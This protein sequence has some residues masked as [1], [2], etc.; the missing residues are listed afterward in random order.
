MQSK[1]FKSEE[2]STR[3]KRNETKCSPL[4]M[5]LSLGI[6]TRS[7]AHEFNDFKQFYDVKK[8][9]GTKTGFLLGSGRNS[10]TLCTTWYKTEKI[11][12][13]HIQVR[14]LMKL[15]PMPG[16]RIENEHR[17]QLTIGD[18][19]FYDYFIGL[20]LNELVGRT[21]PHLIRTLNLLRVLRAPPPEQPTFYQTLKEHEGKVYD[22][23]VITKELSV[24]ESSEVFE[25]DINVKNKK[26]PNHNLV[27]EACRYPYR[28]GVSYFFMADGL[29]LGNFWRSYMEMKFSEPDYNAKVDALQYSTLCVLLQVYAF[30]HLHKKVF[31]HNDL[32]SNNIFLVKAPKQQV[33]VF[34]YYEMIYDE[35]TKRNEKVLVLTFRSRYLVKIIDYGRCYVKG[36]TESFRTVVQQ[37]DL[38]DS[39]K[40]RGCFT[41]AYTKNVI[42][43]IDQEMKLLQEEALKLTFN[44][45]TY[46]TQPSHLKT[47]T[48]LPLKIATYVQKEIDSEFTVSTAYR[49][50]FNCFSTDT[51][52]KNK[53]DMFKNFKVCGEFSILMGVP[54]ENTASNEDVTAAAVSVKRHTRYTY[55]HGQQ[56]A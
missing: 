5:C 2:T 19:I 48:P 56:T 44:L 12:G 22:G 16:H 53:K 31:R 41:N 10:I 38:Y 13:K 24:I 47:P 6:Y 45:K 7:I 26:Q 18:N 30:L 50:L 25:S 15:T 29:T 33:F 8:N 52:K 43:N 17:E 42:D 9:I 34:N 11:R 28:F 32:H 23:K 55:K 51:V 49:S 21:T 46:D 1:N 20:G 54:V 35:N 39:R 37:Y 14:T 36:Y 3:R 27:R 40:H 4:S